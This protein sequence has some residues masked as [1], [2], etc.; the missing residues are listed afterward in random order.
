MCLDPASAALLAASTAASAVGSGIQTR[1]NNRYADSVAAARNEQLRLT[2]DKQKQL[3]EQNQVTLADTFSKF[4]E[5]NQTQALSDAQN[6]RAAAVDSATTAPAAND[7]PLSGSAPQVIKGAVA[8]R[9]LEAFTSATDKNKRLAKLSGYND[10]TFGNNLNVNS[11]GRNIETQNNFSRGEISLLPYSQDFA[12]AQVKR[13]DNTLG[14]VLQ[15]AGQ[16]GAGAAGRGF[17]NWLAPAAATGAG[18]AAAP[19][20]FGVGAQPY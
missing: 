17:A 11:A 20:F 13:P 9:L 8:Q 1:N 6:T 14:M 12:E 3:G 7:V 18:K 19:I 2:R 16:I 10:T 4:A 15:T 5:P